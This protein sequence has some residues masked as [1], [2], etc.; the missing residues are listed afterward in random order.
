MKINENLKQ[1]AHKKVLALINKKIETAQN[2]IDAAIE[3]RDN[4]TKSS[5]GDKYE[6]GRAMMQNEQQR[7][8][9][10]LAIALGL[11]SDMKQIPPSK[12]SIK[13]EAGALL[14]LGETIIYVSV[15]LG[16]IK[17]DQLTIFAISMASPLG[18]ALHNKVI[19]DKI[20][21]KEKESVIL[22]I[23]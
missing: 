1:K 23:V 6:T 22:A 13:V 20:M 19:G 4:E 21:F 10:R 11:K 5:V 17:L 3:S 18:Q 15:G 9:V 2:A 16:K 12:T 7:N 14:N 8:E